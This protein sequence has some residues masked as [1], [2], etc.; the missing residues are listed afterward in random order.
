M[1]YKTQC[2][3]RVILLVSIFLHGCKYPSPEATTATDGSTDT[4]DFP[5]EACELNEDCADPWNPI[6]DEGLCVP[7]TSS[8]ECTDANYPS[9]IN[10]ACGTPCTSNDAKESNDN[11]MEA[12]AVSNGSDFN[13]TLCQQT[14]TY[15]DTEDWF[16]F[17]VAGASYI[18]IITN[19][20]AHDGDFDLTLYDDSSNIID[21]SA[22]LFY[23]A[24]VPRSV[25]AIHTRVVADTYY[26]R[27]RANDGAG[28]IPYRLVVRVLTE[29]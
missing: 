16:T 10:G 18:S 13:L 2:L 6:C 23:G 8:M 4:G 19:N 28:S 29:G 12:K 20:D 25:E 7:C 9:C 26:I 1:G 15:Y 17:T 14:G 5:L 22:N 27:I 11:L 3:G 24:H 21:F